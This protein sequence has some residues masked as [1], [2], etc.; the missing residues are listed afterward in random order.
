ML[1]MAERSVDPFSYPRFIKALRV[2]LIPEMSVYIVDDRHQEKDAQVRNVY[3]D[4][5][6]EDHGN[7]LF[8]QRLQRMKRIC[9]P[10]R[11]IGGL[12]MHQVKPP[13][14]YPVMHKTV[15]EIKIGVVQ[16]EQSR[17]QQEVIRVSILPDIPVAGSIWRNLR[18]MQENNN[19]TSDTD[20]C[21]GKTDLPHIIL[22]SGKPLLYFPI[23]KFTS[24]Y[25]IKCKKSNGRYGKVPATYQVQ[26]FK[27]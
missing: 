3:G 8:H 6:I 22:I 1:V 24:Q 25:Y 13:E 10:G 17:K 11:W 12:M 21:Q 20:G 19:E 9:R 27:V 15:H 2:Q 26:Y 14:Q 4:G 7:A 16:D 18:M 23:E 5:E